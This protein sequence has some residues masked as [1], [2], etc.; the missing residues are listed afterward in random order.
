MTI[1]VFVLFGSTTIYDMKNEYVGDT[2]KQG[3]W[4]LR[5]NLISK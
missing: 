1:A 4:N 5:R 2:M 3:A